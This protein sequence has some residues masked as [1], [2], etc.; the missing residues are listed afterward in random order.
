MARSQGRVHATVVFVQYPGVS[1]RWVRTDTWRQAEAIPGVQVVS[2]LNG[3]LSHQF[4][5]FTSGQTY[6]YDGHGRLLFS[7]GLT[8][9]RGHEGDNAGLSAALAILRGRTPAQTRTPVFG[10]PLFSP[11]Q[12]GEK[13]LPRHS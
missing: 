13:G 7:G 6:L 5:A 1:A 3:T 2:D 10:C 9:E 8:S 12:A 11:P 4:G